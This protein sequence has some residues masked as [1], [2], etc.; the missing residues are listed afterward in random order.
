MHHASGNHG[1]FCAVAAALCLGGCTSL[2]DYFHHGCKV[3]PEYSPAKAA[4]APQWIDAADPRVRSHAADLSGWWRVFHDPVLDDL[5]DRAYNQNINLKEYGTRILQARAQLGIAT[6]E[7]FPQAQSASGGYSR[8]A[9]SP[10]A[11]SDNW[12]LGFNLAWELD[13]WGLYRRQVLGAK[14]QLEGS[15]ENYDAVLVT[16]LGDT[17]QDYVA[18]RQAQEQIELAKENAQLQREVLKIIQARFEGGAVGGLDVYQQQS[19]LSGTEAA[20]P[21]LEIALR[22]SQ[23]Q[24]CTLLGIPPTDLQARLGRRPIPAAPS[25]VV[26]DIPARLIERRPDIRAA[27]RTAAAQAEQIGIAQAALYPHI[28]ITGTLGYSAL[29]ASRLFTPANFNGSL[30]PSFTWNI[31]NYGRISNNV[32]LQ[33]ATFQQ[34]L[35]D[36]RTAVLTANQEAEDGL[37]TFLRSQEQ[38][39]LIAEGMV[40]AKRAYQIVVSQYQV[41]AVDYTRLAQVQGTMVSQED[42]EAQARGAIA[43][44]L[45]QVYRALGGGWEIRLGQAAACGLPQPG[46]APAGTT[47]LPAT[48]AVA[49][50][51]SSFRPTPP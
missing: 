4:V 2:S 11:F 26:V 10:S 9:V 42:S 3:G 7:I 33:D 36:Y 19:A 51:L 28:A 41:G 46:A 29:N 30:G 50:P 32:R 27:E 24:L 39:K 37:V 34:A 38:R 40:A 45:I 44:G 14:A 35:L 1:L 47:N 5:I 31:L 12:S 18:L 6:G 25:E 22:K 21:A 23:N 8:E 49:T 16:L 48:K 17:A 15:L 20:I 13:F 43:L